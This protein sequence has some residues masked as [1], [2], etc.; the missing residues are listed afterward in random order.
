MTWEV[1]Q[2]KLLAKQILSVPHGKEKQNFHT[3]PPS[4]LLLFFATFPSFTPFPGHPLLL[5]TLPRYKPIQQQVENTGKVKKNVGLKSV[6]RFLG[7][8]VCPYVVEEKLPIWLNSPQHQ[9][10][11]EVN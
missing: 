1:F 6:L 7:F 11:K 3:Y 9:K 8:N 5:S 10:K 4:T 2:E